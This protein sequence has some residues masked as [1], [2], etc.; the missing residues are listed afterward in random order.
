MPEILSQSEI[1]ELLN[2]LMTD[3]AAKAEAEAEKDT[4]RVKEYDF[5]TP[6]KL[7]KEQMKTLLGIHENFASIWRPISPAF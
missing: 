2:S 3:G 6:K 1:D 4:R 5:K 7:T